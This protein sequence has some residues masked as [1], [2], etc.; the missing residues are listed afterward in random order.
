MLM[1]N[2]ACGGL[3]YLKQAPRTVALWDELT[4]EY[5]RRMI[6]GYE[7]GGMTSANEN[8]QEVVV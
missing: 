6:A 2:S 5:K 1:I 8:D 3:V 4:S 7:K